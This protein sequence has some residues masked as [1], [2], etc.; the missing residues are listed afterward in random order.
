MFKALFTGLPVSVVSNLSKYKLSTVLKLQGR[1]QYV[2]AWTKMDA[3][4]R[5][6]AVSKNVSGNIILMLNFRDI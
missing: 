2:A 4:M 3:F 6:A 5:D 1:E